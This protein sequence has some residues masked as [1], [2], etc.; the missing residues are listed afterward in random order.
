LP[1]A[2]ISY[3]LLLDRRYIDYQLDCCKGPPFSSTSGDLLKVSIMQEAAD[4]F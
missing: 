3:L 2:A 1:Q 4:N